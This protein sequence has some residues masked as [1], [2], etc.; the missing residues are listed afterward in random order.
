ME[1][2]REIKIRQIQLQIALAANMSVVA[3]ALMKQLSELE[4]KEELTDS[5]FNALMSLL[6]E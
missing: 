4:S 3:Q 6:E 5:N 2:I 1:Q